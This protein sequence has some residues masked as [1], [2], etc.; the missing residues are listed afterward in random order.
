V[1]GVVALFCIAT[2]AALKRLLDFGEVSHYLGYTSLKDYFPTMS[3]RPSAAC[4]NKLCQQA[5]QRWAAGASERQAQVTR[6][7]RTSVQRW[8]R[9]ISDAAHADSVHRIAS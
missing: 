7:G 2:Q 1:E 9:T 5:Q 8:D 4:V 6:K 3:I